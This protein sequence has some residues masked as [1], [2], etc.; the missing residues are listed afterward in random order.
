MEVGG[1]GICQGLDVTGRDLPAALGL[2]QDQQ[3]VPAV[4]SD[5]GLEDPCIPPV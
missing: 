4:L 5:P 3:P 1:P 2:A